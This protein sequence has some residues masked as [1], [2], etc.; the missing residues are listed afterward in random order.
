MHEEG[1]KIL[2]TNSTNRLRDN[3]VAC[4][5]IEEVGQAI[6]A[7]KFALYE[8]DRNLEME[9]EIKDRWK[10]TTRCIP[11]EGQFTDDMLTLKNPENVK[12][13]ISRNF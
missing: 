7:G 10:A 12:V 2:L 4:T 13:I 6:E 1:Q 5:S 11:F 3:T 8:W 9:K